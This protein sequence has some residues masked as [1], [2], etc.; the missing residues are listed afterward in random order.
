MR[1]WAANEDM[2]KLLKHPISKVGFVDLNTGVNWPQ[3]TFTTRRI[4]DGDVKTS[5]PEQAAQPPAPAP[6]PTQE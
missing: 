4:R 3:D 1:V 2:V 5:A 6:E